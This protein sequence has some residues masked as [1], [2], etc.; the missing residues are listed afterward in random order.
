MKTGKSKPRKTC[1]ACWFVLPDEAQYCPNCGRKV[2]PPKSPFMVSQRIV[3]LV[4]LGWL[5]VTL[6]VVSEPVPHLM[7][8]VV[9]FFVVLGLIGSWLVLLAPA[10]YRAIRSL[11]WKGL[12]SAAGYLLPL[13]VTAAVIVTALIYDAPLRARLELSEGA[14]VD[15]AGRVETQHP[16]SYHLFRF[17]GLFRVESVYKRDGCT[18]FVTEAFGPE[19]EGGLA[20]CM[21]RLPC[22]PTVEMD[23]IKG[24]WWRWNY[25]HTN[26]RC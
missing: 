1:T 23:H 24:D 12:A 10:A 20:Y 2:S 17:I 9:E 4:T 25:W 11:S 8:L 13:P 15:H 22:G 3:L 26:E 16:D 21:G 19:D 5:L 7:L 6:F 18:I 14:L